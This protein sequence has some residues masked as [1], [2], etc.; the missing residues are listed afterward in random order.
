MEHTYAYTFRGNQLTF[1]CVGLIGMKKL[2]TFFDDV[3]HRVKN[4]ENDRNWRQISLLFF[5]QV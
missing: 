3:K 2:G 5:I 4:I 1:Y